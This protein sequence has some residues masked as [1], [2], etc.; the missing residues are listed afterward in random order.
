MC[1]VYEVPPPPLAP[2]GC[3]EEGQCSG[4]YRNTSHSWFHHSYTS[5][6]HRPTSTS[7]TP[8]TCSWKHQLLTSRPC[9]SQDWHCVL[10]DTREKQR[11]LPAGV[12]HMLTPVC[13]PARIKFRA[14]VRGHAWSVELFLSI[15]RIVEIWPRTKISDTVYSRSFE[16]PAMHVAE[17]FL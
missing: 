9:T 3:H 6:Q 15:E 2:T 12:C 1:G 14:H 5:S 8:C 13:Q 4:S 11:I 10:S 7:P 17:P 16:S